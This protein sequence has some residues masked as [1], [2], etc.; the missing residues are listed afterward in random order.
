MRQNG[1]M[2][3]HQTLRRLRR[4]AT[5]ATAAVAAGTLLAGAPANADV[6]IAQTGCSDSRSPANATNTDT[7]AE[8]T[9]TSLG[10]V[11]VRGGTIAGGSY[12]WGRVTQYNSGSH[13]VLFEMDTNNDGVANCYLRRQLGN[14]NYTNAMQRRSG[15][16]FR[17]CYAV[18]STTLSCTGLTTRTA[19]VS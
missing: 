6:E 5:Y 16:R 7:F 17:T 2:M 19:W 3:A 8:N 14:L 11:Q 9:E 18:L 15:A 12:R 4:L 13:Y 1:Q 10:N